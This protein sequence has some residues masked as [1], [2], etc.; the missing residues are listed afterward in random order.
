MTPHGQI[1]THVDPRI[2]LLATLM[3]GE[4]KVAIPDFC[5]FTFTARRSYLGKAKAT[6]TD[7]RVRHQTE[8]EKQLYDVLS[9]V[10]QRPGSVLSSRWSEPSLTIHNID[11]SGP[12]S[13]S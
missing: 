12:K 6:F 1:R 13:E 2:R 3:D 8:P 9:N 5:S 10:T 11:V 7:D 4:G